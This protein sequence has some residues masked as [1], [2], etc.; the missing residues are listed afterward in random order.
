[1]GDYFNALSEFLSS[2]L[3]KSHGWVLVVSFVFCVA[4]ACTVILFI[5]NKITIPSKTIEANNVKQE[6]E[7]ISIELEQAKLEISELKNKNAELEEKL[8]HFKFLKAL[9]YEKDE[10]FE[11]K[12]LTDF[13]K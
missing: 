11:D 6:N 8:R 7:R 10:C 5:V 4:I 3:A 13:T 12:A 2:D 1:M 9:E